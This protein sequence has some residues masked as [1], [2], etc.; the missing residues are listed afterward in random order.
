MK[1]G[2]VGKSKTCPHIHTQCVRVPAVK[3]FR[4]RRAVHAL[5][6]W[7]GLLFMALSLMQPANPKG[8]QHPCGV[9]MLVVNALPKINIE[10]GAVQ[11]IVLAARKK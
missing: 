6:V 9:G 1:C 8:C 10:K 5:V 2:Y 11:A 7:A 3:N 4:T